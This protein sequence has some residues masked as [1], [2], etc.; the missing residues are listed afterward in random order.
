VIRRQLIPPDLEVARGEDRYE[1]VSQEALIKAACDLAVVIDQ[2]GG[3]GEILVDRTRTQ[4]PGE[5]LTT[6]AVTTWKD[7]T[8]AKP[9]PEQTDDK[10]QV[11][12][13]PTPLK[14][15][16]DDGVVRDEKGDPEVDETAV[17]PGLRANA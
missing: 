3:C 13:E 15:V 12:T 1:V 17:P 6:G 11:V 10:Q 7:R 14:A 9:Q 2:C 5:A 16:P 8:D 4:I